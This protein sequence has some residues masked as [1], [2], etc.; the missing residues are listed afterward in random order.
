MKTT[1][2]LAGL[3]GLALAGPALAQEALDITVSPRATPADPLATGSVRTVRPN[4]NVTPSNPM[5]V[6]GFDGPPGGTTSVIGD[7]E[8]LAPGSPAATP[9]AP[10]SRP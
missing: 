6:V 1:L 4:P 9:N 5:G 10:F 3:L 2:A 7:D 8:P